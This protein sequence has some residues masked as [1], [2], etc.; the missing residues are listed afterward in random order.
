M[1]RVWYEITD[2]TAD[3]P[4]AVMFKFMF[5]PTDA[6]L[7]SVVATFINAKQDREAKEA[8]LDALRQQVEALQNELNQ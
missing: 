2:D 1:W 4:E 3:K 7:Q 8:A 6:E 5:K